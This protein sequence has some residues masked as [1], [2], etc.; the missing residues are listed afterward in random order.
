[1][2]EDT[3]ITLLLVIGFITFGSFLF[4]LDIVFG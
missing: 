1:M 3:P 2:L 4:I